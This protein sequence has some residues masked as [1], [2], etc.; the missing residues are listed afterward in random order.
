M[1]PCCLVD[2]TLIFIHRHKKLKSKIY[3]VFYVHVFLISFSSRCLQCSFL[4]FLFVSLSSFLFYSLLLFFSIS[5]NF[6]SSL[7]IPV[8]LFWVFKT[9]V[10]C[11]W[12][13]LYHTLK[14]N[15]SFV[16]NNLSNDGQTWQRKRLIPICA[17]RCISWL[18]QW[19]S[20]VHKFKSVHVKLT[21]KKCVCSDCTVTG[22]QDRIVPSYRLGKLC[23]AQ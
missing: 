6:C 15:F 9:H 2:N 3:V 5:S 4:G 23:S 18:I 10:L 19:V 1:T 8:F 16:N 11:N 7:V 13:I 17:I 12:T 20:E 21:Y 14:L 22:L